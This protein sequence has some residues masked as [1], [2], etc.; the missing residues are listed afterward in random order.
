MNQIV[1]FTKS[2]SVFGGADGPTSVFVAGK[3]AIGILIGILV[4]SIFVSFFGLKIVRVLTTLV[5]FVIGACAG[6]AVAVAAGA[7][8]NTLWI[9]VLVCAL[10]F[11]VLSG[12][13]Y[14][15]GVFWLT[16]VNSMAT[17]ISI[18]SEASLPVALVILAV[19]L[20]LAILAAV[21]VEPIVVVI[22]AVCGGVTAGGMIAL[23]AD[24]P[25][26]TGY[27]AGAGIAVAGMLIQFGMHSRKV[28]KKEKVYSAEMKEKVSMESEVEKARNIL[29]DD[30][31]EEE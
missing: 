19:S 10:V 22:T 25:S 4:I 20:I 26:W 16:F 15:F 17:L 11:A 2:I 1:D 13:L 30:D 9:I 12:V 23:L 14:R 27:A 8:D 6:A 24:L 21:Y 18:I 31:E 5:G 28:G 7:E 29:D 3:P